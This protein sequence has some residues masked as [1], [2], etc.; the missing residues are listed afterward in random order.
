M[1]NNFRNGLY[2]LK[3]KDL[4]SNENTETDNG[5]LNYDYPYTLPA[6]L[7]QRMENIQHCKLEENICN[8][9][10]CKNANWHAKNFQRVPSLS[11][12]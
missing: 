6:L 2:M 7:L 12:S 11:K 3:V 10:G 8:E 1:K 5:H 9:T 4:W